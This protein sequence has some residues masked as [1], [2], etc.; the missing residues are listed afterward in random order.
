M[1]E[2]KNMN[3]S[4]ESEPAS[5]VSE[6]GRL[7]VEPVGNIIVARVRGKP[8]AE[9]IRECQRRVIALRNDTLCSRIMYDALELE[10]PPIEIVLTQQAL[11][12]DLK[13][14]G[15]KIAIVVP[16]TA[17]A[18][19]ARL[20]FGEANHRV[21]YNDISMAVLWLSDRETG[22]CVSD[23]GAGSMLPRSFQS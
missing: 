15:V 22:P 2:N 7:W 19:L 13:D 16:N 18:Y 1:A 8:T 9:L 10:R 11:T 23:R 3:K 21:F 4:S 12:D 5:G 20:A 6:F 14:H 17:I